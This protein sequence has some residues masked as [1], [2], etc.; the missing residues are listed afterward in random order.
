MRRHLD[1]RHDLSQSRLRHLPQH[2]CHDPPERR[3]AHGDR[4]FQDTPSR[5]RLKELIAAMDITIRALLREN[6]LQ[7]TL[8]RRSQ[9]TDEQLIDRMLAHPILIIRPIVV[10]PKGARLYRPSE[11]VLEILPNPEIGRFVK[12]DGEIV[13][14]PAFKA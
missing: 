2:A 12:E 4:V 3:R 7:G 5:E 8:P 10:T 11:V 1:K 6:T 9:V 14:A 13:E